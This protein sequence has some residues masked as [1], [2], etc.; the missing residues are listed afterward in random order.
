[1]VVFTVVFGGLA[2]LPSGGVA[3]PVMVFAALLPW[4]LFAS[5][6]TECGTS[7]QRNVNLVSKVYFP[8]LI[9][10]LSAVMVSL[11]DFVIAF[12][13]FA[14]MMAWYGIVPGMKMVFLPLFLLLAL[15]CAL[16]LG[17]WLAA[18]NVKYRDVQMLIPYVVQV[19][20]FASPVGYASDIVPVQWRSL[21]S[22]NPMVGVIDGF[23]WALGTSAG[24]PY[25]A[26]VALSFLIA[27]LLFASG[28][29]Y[30]RRMERT[31][32]DVI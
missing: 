3:Y 9:V 30:F 15:L 27:A 5:G 31:F 17:L 16:G 24:E 19:G 20:L 7:L 6:L 11:V 22:L 26:S 13:V 12:V 2:G 28:V 32:A 1:M 10:P 25:W 29:W 21:Y 14:G 18:L 23:R 4:Q 8:R